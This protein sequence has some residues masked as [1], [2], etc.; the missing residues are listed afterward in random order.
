MKKYF[1]LDNPIEK[2]FRLSKQECLYWKEMDG[3]YI[4]TNDYFADLVEM[5]TQD[6]IGILDHDFTDVFLADKFRIND[7]QVIGNDVTRCFFEY[8]EFPNQKS[9]LALSLKTPLQNSAGNICG[10][11]G[12][13]FDLME[14]NLREIKN[15]LK[16]FSSVSFDPSS[17]FLSPAANTIRESLSRREQEFML[18][19]IRGMTVKEAAANMGISS[20]TGRKHLNSAKSKLDC[21]SKSKLIQ[22][23]IA[24]LI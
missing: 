15:I 17:L 5:R 6:M 12:I 23:V 24:D 20:S 10:V 4:G 21:H 16:K 2:F 18:L 14:Y 13:S 1:V 11:F 19:T 3:K 7:K 9:L 8:G 22:K